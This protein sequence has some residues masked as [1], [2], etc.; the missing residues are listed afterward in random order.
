MTFHIIISLSAFLL[1][2]LGTRLTILAWRKRPQPVD[3]A[4][5]RQ[6]Q[7]AVVR[8]GGVVLIFTLIICLLIADLN[9]G[10][11]LSILLLT[12]ISLLDELIGVPLPIRIMVQVM[13][14]TVP[15]SLTQTLLFGGILPPWVDKGLVGLAWIG[16]SNMFKAMDDAD[17]MAA[18]GMISLGAGLCLV[19]VVAGTFSDMLSTY[20]LIVATAGCGFLWWNW[21]P[22]KIQMGDV[23]SAPTG[24]IA[25]YLLLMAALTHPHAALIL[26]AYYV[27]DCVLTWIKRLNNTEDRFIPY[28]YEKAIL[29]GR[30]PAVVLRYIIGINILLIFLALRSI[31]DPAIAWFHTGLAYMISFVLLWWF[32]H[33]KVAK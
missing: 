21:P 18:T 4:S 14:I 24:F 3:I 20:S 27:S 5:L 28:C 9:Y 30:R 17:G 23:G 31:T 25:G 2:L 32:S 16:F 33:K 10:I 22:A 26:P 8:G 13:A 7:P 12:A 19:T 15:L 11:V 29:N 1:A 6:G